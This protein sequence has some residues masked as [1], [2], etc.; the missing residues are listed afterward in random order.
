MITRYITLIFI[1]STLVSQTVEQI[2]QAKKIIK[3]TGMSEA[4]ARQMAKNRGYTEAQIENALNKAQQTQN[5]PLPNNNIQSI[6]DF[7]NFENFSS[8]NEQSP[9]SQE[10]TEVP[11]INAIGNNLETINS[12][13]NFLDSLLIQNSEDLE[14]YGYDIFSRDPS[15]FQAS[16]IGAVDPDYLI[17]PGD[18]IILML[19][20]ETQFRQVLTV[21]REGFIFIPEVGQVFVNGLN[22]NLL[23]S[24]L[25]RVLSQS[26][27]SLNP[28]GKKATTFL[29]VS[30]GNLRPLRIQV[31]GQVAQ[32]GVYT[33]SPS[34][35][36]F[37][38]LYYFNGP[39]NFGSLREIHLIRNNEKITSIDFYDYL[40]T[41][42]KPKDMKLQLDDIVFIPQRLKTV[43]IEGEVNRPGVY[44]LKPGETLINIIDMSGGLSSTAYLDRVQIDRIVPFDERSILGMDRMFKDVDLGKLLKSKQDFELQ[45]GDKIRI[46]S[47]MSLRQNSVSISGAISRP[48]TYDIGKSLKLSE[49]II[50]SDSLLGDAYLDRVDIV[51]LR[52]DFSEE[53]IKLDLF[54][55]MS[56]DSLNDIF[57]KGLDKVKIYGINE[58]I[59]QSF[60]SITGNVK[61]PGRYL[62]Q[63]NLTL[64]DIIF[65]SG[66][67]LDDEHKL[68]TYM[69]RSELIRISDDTGEKEIIPFDLNLVLEK[70]GLAELPLKQNDFIRIYSKEEIE[71]STQFVSI[72][73]HVKSP[74]SYELFEGN[75]RLYDLI[76]KAGGF[77]DQTH[78]MATYLDR[79][80]LYRYEGSRITK[81]VIPFNLGAVLD[82]PSSSDNI[83]LKP[84]DDIK[85]YSKT[86]FNG[87]KS[88]NV[89]GAVQNPGTYSY[90]ENMFLKDAILEAGG[91]L[92]DVYK[93]NVEI[94]RIDPNSNSEGVFAKSFNFSLHK[95]AMFSN[96]GYNPNVSENNFKIKAYDLINIR[97]DPYFQMQKTV[98]VSGAIKFP[99]E[100]VILSPE[101]T[102]YDIIIRAGGLRE[103]AYPLASQFIRSNQQVNIDLKKILKNP[104]SLGNIRVQE[105][106]NLIIPTKPDVIQ[107]V[108][109]VSAPGFY[110]HIKGL[111]VNDVIDQAG[112][113]SQNAMLDDIYIRFPNGKSKKY[114]R[115]LSNPKVKD[116]SIITVGL[117]PEEE[118]FDRTEYFTDL[119]TIIVNLAQAISLIIIARG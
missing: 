6:T 98:T 16:S 64:Y 9:L 7:N 41:G 50:K 20:G 67:F 101:E 21:N 69:Q 68:S 108:G 46:F 59:P 35:T 42:R 104:R 99:G 49:L 48:G 66:G 92:D 56:G 1:L 22:L 58:M 17:G 39:T 117:K 88:V 3:Q 61:Q 106:D 82:N 93:Y 90:K 43:T 23:E 27:A 55:A 4:Q 54:K 31:L 62:L 47:V 13:E 40:L 79:G 77:E 75:M 86:V 76:F 2:D 105:G 19:W 80:D 60:I 29:D 103:S 71:G 11:T 10:E 25:F 53:L 111:R 63:K 30:L 28:D 37:S 51:R 36:V 12:D 113:F 18:E 74:G 45:D 65:K 24:K 15:L 73:G 116:G 89:V 118:P 100:Y 5:E 34:S 114:S 87:F 83:L 33:V 52:P 14:F 96:K 8:T 81:T 85:I 78:K 112:G 84:G 26:Y 72:S 107:V 70:K 109:E 115:W 102:I 119:T 97:P 91:I 95:D 44:E 32:P 110:K 38:S 57:L 94:A